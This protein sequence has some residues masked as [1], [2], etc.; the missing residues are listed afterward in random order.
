MYFRSRGEKALFPKI[1]YEVRAVQR[2]SFPQNLLSNTDLG[3]RK[4]N[5]SGCANILRHP[6]TLVF[7]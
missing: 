5:V 7:L 6:G 1:G 2:P 4:R 3:L